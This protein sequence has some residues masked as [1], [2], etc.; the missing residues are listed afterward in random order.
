MPPKHTPD[1]PP[2]PKPTAFVCSVCG[3]SFSRKFNLQRHVELQKCTPFVFPTEHTYYVP[4]I[5]HLMGALRAPVNDAVLP[6]LWQSTCISVHASPHS[7]FD[8]IWKLVNLL[9]PTQL[10]TVFAYDSSVVQ[11]PAHMSTIVTTLHAHLKTLADAGVKHIGKHP[12][13]EMRAVLPQYPAE[14]DGAGE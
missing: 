4:L 6:Y 2:K 5:K 3:R 7:G 8:A 13:A 10:H 14:D 11:P 9:S 1:Q 12:I